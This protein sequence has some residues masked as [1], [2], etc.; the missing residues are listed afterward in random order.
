VASKLADTQFAVEAKCLERFHRVLQDD[1]CRAYYGPDHVLKA[2]KMGAIDTLMIS[3]SLFRC[4]DPSL[5]R[6]YIALV[7][8]VRSNGG[9][10]LIYSSMH[11]TGERA[12]KFPNLQPFWK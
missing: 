4:A 7:A 10:A 1:A 5:R 6:R 3:D 2:S 11:V 8:K 9:K 12:F